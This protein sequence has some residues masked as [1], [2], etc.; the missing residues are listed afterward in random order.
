M[1]TLVLALL[2]PFGAEWLLGRRPRLAAVALAAGLLT[3]L[4]CSLPLRRDAGG[5]VREAAAW[6]RANGG[7]ARLHTNSLQ[8]AYLSGAPVAWPLVT[9]AALTGPLDGSASRPGD[10]WAVRLTPADAPIRARLDA[11]PSFAPRAVFEG[12][13]GDA[14]RIY[15][16]TASAGCRSGSG[17]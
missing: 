3:T 4:A 15:A 10:L 11:L 16:C 6:V 17:E 12:E 1:A 9:R 13:G 7:G 14:V 5:H 8:L 2:A